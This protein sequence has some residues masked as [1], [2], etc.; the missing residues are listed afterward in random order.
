MYDRRVARGSTVAQPAVA[1]SVKAEQERMASLDEER[2]KRKLAESRK[3]GE[4]EAAARALEVPPVAGRS[5]NAVR[6]KGFPEVAGGGGGAIRSLRLRAVR[7]CSFSLYCGSPK[8]T[9]FTP[10]AAPS[11]TPPLLARRFKRKRTWR[12]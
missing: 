11:S 10:L 2:R 9:P 12:R 7:A 1:P 6:G 3:R 4:A 5:H 8:N